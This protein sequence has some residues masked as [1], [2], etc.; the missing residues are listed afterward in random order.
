MNNNDEVNIQTF[1]F[2]I[3]IQLNLICSLSVSV[4]F[5][6]YTTHSQDSVFCISTVISLKIL[7]LFATSLVNSLCS[8]Q[9]SE[10]RTGSGCPLG[11]DP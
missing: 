8:V 7:V 5:D 10:A 11:R 6:H 9:D 2:T 1:F 3:N 4:R